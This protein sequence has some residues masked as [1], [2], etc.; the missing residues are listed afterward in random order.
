MKIFFLLTVFVSCFSIGLEMSRGLEKRRRALSE[1]VSFLDFSET[2]LKTENSPTSEIIACSGFSL[3]D[4]VLPVADAEK[5]FRLAVEKNFARTGFSDADLTLLDS[6]FSEFGKTD[7]EGQLSL[8]SS[9]REVAE[10][11]LSDAEADK[12]KYSK[13]Y[14]SFGLLVG[15]VLVII[16]I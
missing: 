15:V 11:S 7:A 16:F 10:K 5:S 6:F 9:V 3:F 4:G 2:R 13:P 1:F 12:T 8:V 14:T